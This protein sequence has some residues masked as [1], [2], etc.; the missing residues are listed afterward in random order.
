MSDEQGA[1]YVCLRYNGPEKTCAGAVFGNC[2]A[3]ERR[4]LRVSSAVGADGKHENHH[5]S[6]LRQKPEWEC[7]DAVQYEDTGGGRSDHRSLV[8]HSLTPKG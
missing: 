8:L 7:A 4:E 5:K 6:S 1:C 2:I 3:R